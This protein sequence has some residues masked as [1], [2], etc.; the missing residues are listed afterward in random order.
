MSNLLDRGRIT[1]TVGATDAAT[2]AGCNTTCLWTFSKAVLGLHC[3]QKLGYEVLVAPGCKDLYKY[4]DGYYESTAA[5]DKA[6]P[7]P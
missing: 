7:C 1:S 6:H 5:Y 2:V 4:P 3:G